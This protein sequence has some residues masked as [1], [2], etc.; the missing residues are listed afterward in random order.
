MKVE[1]DPDKL[2]YSIGEVA[3]LFGVSNSLIRFWETEFK[4]LK[5]QKNSRGDRKYA[6]KDIKVLESIY[7]VVKEKGYTIDGAKKALSNELKV[8]KQI[9]G[10]T[11]K[12]TKVKNSL[13]K[14]KKNL[15]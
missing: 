9:A 8:Q 15:A 11:K 7:S 10:L 1:L 12:L 5:P 13:A 6:E 2:Y 4:Q 3:K 14:L